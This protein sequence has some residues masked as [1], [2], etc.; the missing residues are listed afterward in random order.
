MFNVN[1]NNIFILSNFDTISSFSICYEF[2]MQKLIH[3]HD[4]RGVDL[5]LFYFGEI[6][7]PLFCYYFCDFDISGFFN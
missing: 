6:E 5:F 7:V 1:Y 2:Q 3:N 4:H